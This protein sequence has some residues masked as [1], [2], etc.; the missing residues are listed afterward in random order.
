MQVN[1]SD[2]TRT[3]SL[4]TDHSG[5]G[6]G[7]QGLMPVTGAQLPTSAG[8]TFQGPLAELFDSGA[9]PG[10]LAVALQDPRGAI[11]VPNAADRE[12]WSR[13]DPSTLL[14]IRDVADREVGTAWAQP[15]A[16][17]Y[18]RYFTDGNRTVYEGRVRAR[19][20]RLTRATVVAARTL[21]ARWLDEV[22]NGAVLLCEQSS[23]C[24][25]AHDDTNSRNGFVLPDIGSP[26][27][28]LGAGEVAGQLAWI[29]L[30]LG[31]ILARRAPGLGER[32]R[33]EVMERVIHPFLERRDWH[34]L[35]LDG[36]AHN[37]N[38][39]IHGNVLLAALFLVEDL[40]TRA[41]VVSLCIEGLDR[42]AATLP[43]DGAIDEGVSYW[44][45]G[46]CRLL[47][48][49]DL[50]RLASGGVLDATE[51]PPLR[52]TIRFP[53]RM[54][55]DGDW[56]VNVADGPARAGEGRPWHVLHRWARRTGDTAVLTHAESNRSPGTPLVEVSTGLGR[57]LTALHDRDWAGAVP[58]SNPAPA[59]VWLP[60]VEIS[61]NR[62]ASGSSAG[63]TLM[64]KGGHNGEHHNHLDVGSF[65]V[66]ANGIPCLVDVGQPTYTAQT[67]GPDRYGIRAMQSRWHSTP[68][69]W[70]REQ[71]VGRRYRAVVS[72]PAPGGRGLTLELANAYDLA[73]G[74]SIR[75]RAVLQPDGTVT[76]TDRW[77][78]PRPDEVGRGVI[79]ME[80]HYL[81]WGTPTLGAGRVD[82][83]CEHG[84]P[85]V[86]LVWEPGPQARLE[87]WILDDPLLQASWGRALHRLTLSF[88]PRGG[89]CERGEAT[90]T[91]RLQD[92]S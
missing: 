26:Y 61:V 56:Y 47:E 41:A 28:D 3:Y 1:Q 89:Q 10:P 13:L 86:V 76:V 15:L 58:G 42:Y 43:A 17:D 82:L 84:S 67:F 92:R 73:D 51:L 12:A 29:D 5:S 55:L 35:G 85:D 50:L 18:A 23:W 21:E 79:P 22:V 38:P 37:W 4:N 20:E 65:T 44:W 11:P 75:R 91:I 27:L 25:A 34:W 69:P 6:R 31:T 48:A 77:E 70:G 66:A 81:L 71:G 32:I 87:T 9:A 62:P 2:Q 59:A 24:W 80:L 57:V 78:L 63:L 39:W 54:H 68:A 49:L 40:P 19:Q 14:A 64:V 16:C 33:H 46:A 88:P 72:D 60:S 30:V 8:A 52:Q 74:S 36:D 83:R 90:M 45:N 53:M 7:G